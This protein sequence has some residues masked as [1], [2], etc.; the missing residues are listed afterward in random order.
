MKKVFLLLIV[1][2]LLFSCESYKTKKVAYPN[3]YVIEVKFTDNTFDTV[4]FSPNQN[5]EVVFKIK[6]VQM[7]FFSDT[8]IQPTLQ[9]VFASGYL[10]ESVCTNVRKYKIIQEIY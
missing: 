3:T 5:S 8:P 7:G 1:S 4:S 6:T 2:F 9:A 10:S